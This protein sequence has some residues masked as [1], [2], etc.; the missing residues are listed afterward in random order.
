VFELRAQDRLTSA[1]LAERVPPGRRSSTSCSRPLYAILG[2]WKEEYE[3][4]DVTRAVELLD[5]S[6]ARPDQAPV[7]HPSEASASGCN[8]PRDDAQSGDVLLDEPAA[9]P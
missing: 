4:S 5:A 3:S 1:S 6:A 2:R 8:R 7:F 9:G